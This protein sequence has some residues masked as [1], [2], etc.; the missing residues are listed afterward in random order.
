MKIKRSEKFKRSLS[1]LKKKNPVI[2]RQVQ[3]KINQI[4]S[5]SPAEI[6]HF[7][8]LR[9]DMSHLKRVRIG[10][11]VLAFQVKGDTIDFKRFRHHDGAYKR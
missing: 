7:K 11:F 8:N 1:Q 10:S 2:F 4:A 5:L 6:D 3:K 9:G